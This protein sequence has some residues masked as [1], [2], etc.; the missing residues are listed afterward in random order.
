MSDPT[1]D[2][3]HRHA[4]ARARPIRVKLAHVRLINELNEV[5][6][7][8]SGQPY[9]GFLLGEDGSF[10]HYDWLGWTASGQPFTMP[11]NESIDID[12]GIKSWIEAGGV[13]DYP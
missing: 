11:K 9:S 4:G 3:D 10:I 5:A 8:P 6:H 12:E 1:T 7:S 13:V 2:D